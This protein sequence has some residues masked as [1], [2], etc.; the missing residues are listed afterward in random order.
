[1]ARHTTPALVRSDGDYVVLSVSPRQATTLAT[2]ISLSPPDH[3]HD[4]WTGDV[5]LQLAQTAARMQSVAALSRWAFLRGRWGLEGASPASEVEVNDE[6]A[7]MAAAREIALAT[8]AV[9]RA[10]AVAVA[11]AHATATS[12]AAAQ[13]TGSF[14]DGVVSVSSATRASARAD[15]GEPVAPVVSQHRR[16]GV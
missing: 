10:V 11:A 13:A 14:V 3:D 1:M 4:E 5:A 16:V 2:A 15:G 8:D 12:R 9:T 6:R 7:G